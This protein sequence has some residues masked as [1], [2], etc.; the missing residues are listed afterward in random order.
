LVTYIKVFTLVVAI[1]RVF[2]QIAFVYEV[3]N[4]FLSLVFV[5]LFLPDLIL[6][7]EN[8][9][10]GFVIDPFNDRFRFVVVRWHIRNRFDSFDSLVRV[11]PRQEW[12]HFSVPD[13]LI[14][15]P[16]CLVRV[17]E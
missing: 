13:G 8:D 3:G 12:T 16:E 2:H 9:I 5:S 11:G 4:L 10:S 1:D 7:S 14:G 6:L 17:E 15:P